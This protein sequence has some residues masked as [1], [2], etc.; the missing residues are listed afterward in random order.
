MREVIVDDSDD[1]ADTLT[2]GSG[3]NAE[4]LADTRHEHPS[5]FVQLGSYTAAVIF[6]EQPADL[7]RPCELYLA[8]DKLIRVT[9]ASH[10]RSSAAG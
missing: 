1:P 10:W 3:K 8:R 5:Q 7:F 4:R 2:L 6:E 9:I